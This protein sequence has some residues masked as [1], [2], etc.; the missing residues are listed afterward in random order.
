MTA[1]SERFVAVLRHPDG[2]YHQ[3]SDYAR[4]FQGAEAVID[5]LYVRAEKNPR[6]PWHHKG[7]SI[8][9]ITFDRYAHEMPE[10]DYVDQD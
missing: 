8:E 5:R 2:T 4:S 10:H 9:R 6:D 1:D 7:A 3:V